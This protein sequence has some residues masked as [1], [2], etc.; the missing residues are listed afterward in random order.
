MYISESF[1]F[2]FI[3]IVVSIFLL[4]WAIKATNKSDAKNNKSKLESPKYNNE[5]YISL[6]NM[7]RKAY[8]SYKESGYNVVWESDFDG[9]NVYDD[10]SASVGSS[11][12]SAE[13]RYDDQN[14]FKLDDPFFIIASYGILFDRRNYGDY[15][16]KAE[17]LNNRETKRPAIFYTVNTIEHS[18]F[19]LY[20]TKFIASNNRSLCKNTKEL[21]EAEVFKAL[22]IGAREAYYEGEEIYDAK[23]RNAKN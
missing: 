10:D 18:N 13:V 23:I 19:G 17:Y 12:Y 8:E 1:L 5:V 6:R 20:S 16:E 2:G 4:T 22:F 3:V 9:F 11:I 21:G 15:E 7:V 14:H